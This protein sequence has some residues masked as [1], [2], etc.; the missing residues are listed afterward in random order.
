MRLRKINVDR[1]PGIKT[2]FSVEAKKGINLILGPNESGKSSLVRTMLHLLW[3]VPVN[4]SPIIANGEFFQDGKSLLAESNHDSLVTW[5]RDGQ[6]IDRPNLPENHTAFCYKLGVLG[7]PD[8][9][10]YGRRF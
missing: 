4:G 2:P 5:K 6:K 9:I 7:A 10:G 8:S 1:I 3:P